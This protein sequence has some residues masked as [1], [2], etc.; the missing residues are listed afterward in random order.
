M[1]RTKKGAERERER[2]YQQE[3][4][5]V[6]AEKLAIKKSKA[7]DI[8]RARGFMPVFDEDAVDVFFEMFEKVA[9]ESDWPEEKWALLVQ[10]VWTGKA[11]R[12]VAALDVRIGLEYEKLR[13]AVLNAY[14]SVPETYRRKFH[15]LRRHAG[16]SYLD[17]WR[18]QEVIFDRWI[19]SCEAYDYKKLKNFL[20]L[21]QFKISVPKEIEVYL[22]VRDAI[23]PQRAAELADKYEVAH[24]GRLGGG[25]E[26][27]R[28]HINLEDVRLAT[29]IRR[30]GVLVR[31]CL[32]Q[33]NQFKILLEP[34]IFLVR[35]AATCVIRWVIKGT[36]VP[37]CLIGTGVPNLWG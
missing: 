27:R 1:G 8:S 12:A 17:L 6:E 18:K 26:R 2:A 34:K 10:S 5:R 32:N 23:S 20:L 24:G 37:N 28:G 25:Y 15:E 9:R 14:V 33:E 36:G 19:N 16:E 3:M 4:A 22:N 30:R 7:F 21:E 11:Q 31:V 29:P 13:K 35:C